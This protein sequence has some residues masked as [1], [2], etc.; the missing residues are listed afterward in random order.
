ML[1]DDLLNDFV[2]FNSGR[3]LQR[4]HTS[5]SASIGSD[6]AGIDLE[7][8]SWLRGVQVPAVLFWC[9]RALMH[10]EREEK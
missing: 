1:A 4:V 6:T 3:M 9:Q 8:V 2:S 5:T 10:R 7:A